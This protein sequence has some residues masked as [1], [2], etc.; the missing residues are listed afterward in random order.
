MLILPSNQS[1]VTLNVSAIFT[2]MGALGILLACSHTLIV[3]CEQL[4]SSENYSCVIFLL[5]RIN[6]IFSAKIEL[7]SDLLIVSSPPFIYI[8]LQKIFVKINVI[9]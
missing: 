1:I 4:N 8:I 3:C 5:M 7:Y 6:L 2:S 9:F